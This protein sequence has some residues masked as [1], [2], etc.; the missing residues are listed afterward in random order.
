MIRD[1]NK[2]SKLVMANDL[3]Y[4]YDC[5]YVFIGH[6]ERNQFYEIWGLFAWPCQNL[7]A[8]SLIKSLVSFH[9]FFSG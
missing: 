5:V 8:C 4:R 2:L 9:E 3:Y 1:Y 7:Y 6:K